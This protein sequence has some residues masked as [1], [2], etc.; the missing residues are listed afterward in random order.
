MKRIIAL[1]L[2]LFITFSLCGCAKCINTETAEVEVKITDEYHRGTYV[3]PIRAG[4]VTTFVTNPAI[5]RITVE[6]N[7][8]E[9]TISGRDTYNLYKD[10]VGETTIGI[11]ETKTYDD[12][13]VKYNIILLK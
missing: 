7:G 12:E 9:Y 5:Y 2:C 10:K 13:S 11:L 1:L 6:Y 3:T 4:K 8:N